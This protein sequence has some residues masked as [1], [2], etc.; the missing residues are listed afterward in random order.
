MILS[1]KEFLRLIRSENK[2]DYERFKNESAPI[3]VWEQ[4]IQEYPLANEW[5]VRNNTVPV[6]VLGKLASDERVLV[7]SEVARNS[8]ITEDI[9]LILAKD[10]DPSVR[11]SLV[12]NTKITKKSLQILVH[13]PES[14]IADRAKEHLEEFNK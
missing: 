2:E 13:D 5:I 1:A 11:S 9:Q 10:S 6:P 8:R 12:K 3:H 4:L 14:K 7:R